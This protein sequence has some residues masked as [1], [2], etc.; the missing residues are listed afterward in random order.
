MNGTIILWKAQPSKWDN[1]WILCLDQLLPLCQTGEVAS[2]FQARMRI[3]LNNYEQLKLHNL[4][5]DMYSEKWCTAKTL[6]FGGDGQ[7]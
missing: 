1:S 6:Y 2:L 4:V 3:K 7:A 5:V